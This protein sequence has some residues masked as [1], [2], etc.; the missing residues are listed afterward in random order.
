MCL[1]FEFLRVIH[2]KPGLQR[3]DRLVTAHLRDTVPYGGRPLFA[4]CGCGHGGGCLHDCGGHISQRGCG[5]G[6]GS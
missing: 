4:G 3:D 2:V 6:V 1:F 5:G